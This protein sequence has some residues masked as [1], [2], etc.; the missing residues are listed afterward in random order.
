MSY[1][2][3]IQLKLYPASCYAPAVSFDLQLFA[4]PEDEG[5]TE[6][7]TEKRIRDAREKGQ[8]AKSQELGQTLV[9][10]SSIMIIFAFG[11]WI[12]ESLAE[13]TKYFLSSFSTYRVTERR[14][15]TDFYF[16][17]YESGKVVLPVF[18][19]SVFAAVAG[20]LMQVGFMFTTHP[21]KVNWSKLKFDPAT[22]MKKVLFSKQV[23]MNLVKSLFKV[24]AIGFVAYLVIM[25]DIDDILKTPDL[26]IGAALHIILMS[27]FKIIVWTSV[28]L[29][30][31]SVPDYFFQKKELMESLKMTK[32]QLKEEYK[33][34]QGDPHVRARLREMQRNIVMKN[35]I[36]EVPKADVVVTNPTHYAVAL[37]YDSSTMEAPTV[38]AKG[39]DSMAL[40]IR[41]TANENGVVM[42]ENRPLAQRLYKDVEVGDIIPVELFQA[43]TLVYA[44]LY[45]RRE[46]KR[47]I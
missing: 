45:K 34:S 10:I 23:G 30:I 46:A 6:E 8:V 7:P 33:E 19:I 1:F 44:E 35:M 39:V 22:I 21:L 25:G 13:I 27:G 3:N 5:R 12:L 37:K 17:L 18:A 36:R 40:R 31:M 41:Q 38:I 28:L 2:D 47:A 32:Q 24:G 20:N 29:L 11:G 14:V 26:S 16:I 9:V 15:I 43:V 4:S 42:I